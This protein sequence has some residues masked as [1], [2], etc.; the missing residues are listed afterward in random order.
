MPTVAQG[1]TIRLA[2]VYK[3]GTNALVD[4]T[5]PALEVLD[6]GSVIVDSGLPLVRD[7]LGQYHYDWDVAPAAQLGIWTARFTGIIGGAAV[8]ADDPFTVVDPGSVQ[9]S[10]SLITLGELKTAL[11]IAAGDVD[12][13]RD[14][15]LAQAM[16]D[17]SAAVSAYAD[18][19]WVLSTTTEQRSF[20]YDGSG[21]LDIDDAADITAVTYSL[22]GYDQ[23]L[24][25]DQWRAEPYGNTVYT[26]LVLPTWGPGFSPEMGFTRNLDVLYRERGFTG[27]GPTVKVDATWGWTTVP[28]DVK[29]AV[30][31]TVVTM[32]D[33]ASEQYVSESIAGYSHTRDTSRGTVADALP[34]R[35]KSLLAPYVRYKVG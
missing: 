13:L 28:D 10:G 22:G 35:A 23:V 11:N 24:P 33:P 9:P 14:A 6:P 1:G 19:D 34:D 29:R 8:A 2:V 12:P 25:A 15:R 32:A 4:P 30:I 21:F 27:I 7:S 17:A 31:W 20:E 5:A 3:D 16:G 26:Y 18:R